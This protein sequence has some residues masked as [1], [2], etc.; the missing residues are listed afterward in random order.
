M[1]VKLL[2]TVSLLA[3]LGAACDG[4]TGSGPDALENSVTTETLLLG[5]AEGPLVVRVPGGAVLFEQHE[6]VA[7]L[8]GS[9]L[10][11]ASAAP[12]STVLRAIDGATGEPVSSARISGDLEIRV[13]SETGRAAALMDPLPAEWDPAVPLPRARTTIVVADP[14]GGSEPRTFD[15][16]G[17]YEPEAFS[18]DDASLFLIQHLP[19]ETPSVYRVTQLDLRSGEVRPVYGPFK[20]EPELMPGTR[21]QQELSPTAEQ[22][23]TLYSSSRPGY[24][25]HEASVAGGAIVSFVHVLSL[26]DGWA[27]CAGLPEAM[28]D[29]PS[30]EQAMATTPDG[31]RL[32][33]IDAGRALVAILHT[34]T[35]QMRTAP[36]ALPSVDT[37]RRTTAQMSPDGRTLFVAV[38]GGT[39][40]SLVTALDAQTLEVLDTWHVVGAISGL[41]VSSDGSNVYAAVEGRVVLLDSETGDEVRD[42]SVPTDAPV[43]RV[44]PLAG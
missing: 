42:V 25:P 33:V 22:L 24:A 1:R 8:G 26:E 2:A 12:G 17:N 28:W 19:A 36:I 9:W 13:V 23:F 10:L 14:L 3:L 43:V 31:S 38:A 30:A 11:S 34:E 7:S 37:I 44:T 40:G 39:D 27:H 5:T 18:T 35:L 4:S 6:A 15:L 41:G 29:R 20:G 21:L 16:R 32:F